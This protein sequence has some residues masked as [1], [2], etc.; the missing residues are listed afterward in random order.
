MI[1]E[2]VDNG[3]GLDSYLKIAFIAKKDSKA[4]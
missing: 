1:S 4:A 3:T 2:C